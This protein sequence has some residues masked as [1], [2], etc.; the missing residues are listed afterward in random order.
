[1]KSEKKLYQTMGYIRERG[2]SCFPIWLSNPKTHVD[3][4]MNLRGEIS[5]TDKTKFTKD[6]ILMLAEVLKDEEEDKMMMI[7]ELK[8]L[9]GRKDFANNNAYTVYLRS[10]AEQLLH[11]ADA[12]RHTAF[13]DSVNQQCGFTF[14]HDCY[15]SEKLLISYLATA[16][17][18]LQG[19][20]LT[21]DQVWE[22]A[23]ELALM[24]AD[25]PD[26]ADF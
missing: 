22:K 7:N 3:I 26:S 23:M 19:Q 5:K 15:D 20:E 1:M 6:E 13:Y 24:A 16:M 4:V 10:I 14:M 12:G 9:K 2:A 17:R 21:V 8:N 25:S 18:Q 11:H